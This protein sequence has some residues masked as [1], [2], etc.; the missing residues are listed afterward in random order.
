MNGMIDV[1]CHILPG[2]DDGAESMNEAFKL[3]RMEYDQGVRAV[4]LTP[5]YRLGYFET[6]RDE[7]KEKFRELESRLRSVGVYIQIL[8]GCEFHRTQNMAEL[9]RTNKAYT[10]AGSDY[11]LVEFSRSDTFEIIKKT[12][13]ELLLHGFRPIIA[14]V[15][16]YSA[17][18][19]MRKIRYMINSGAYIQVNAGSILGKEGICR[20]RFTRK[21][22]REGYIHLIGSDAHDLRRRSPC[23]GECETFLKHKIGNSETRRLLVENPLKILKNEYI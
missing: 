17:L 5:H 21:L 14:H 2:V 23:M 19:S 18:R 22:L 1:H 8:L 11:V 15:E 13:S 4:I 7:V 10:M 6:E 3:L 16:R 20:K 12:V 9:I